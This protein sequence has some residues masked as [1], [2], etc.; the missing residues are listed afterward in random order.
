MFIGFEDVVLE[1][2]VSTNGSFSASL[3]TEAAVRDVVRAVGRCSLTTFSF[4]MI[5]LAS[6]S[7]RYCL[8]RYIPFLPRFFP[9]H[10][11]RC[12]L[13]ERVPVEFAI[14]PLCPSASARV[15]IPLQLKKASLYTLH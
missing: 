8:K 14:L 3:L 5:V 10:L 7:C 6:A 4:E 11:G 13:A 9:P 15:R 12:L 2:V 1:V